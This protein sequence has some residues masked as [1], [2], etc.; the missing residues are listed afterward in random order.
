MITPTLGLLFHH[1]KKLRSF[2]NKR[3]INVNFQA[4]TVSRLL[5]QCPSLGSSSLVTPVAGFSL[6]R[7]AHP[8]IC[9][10]T[11]KCRN[12]WITKHKYIGRQVASNVCRLSSFMTHLCK[13]KVQNVVGEKS[14]MTLPLSSLPKYRIVSNNFGGLNKQFYGNK[15]LLKYAELK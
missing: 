1:L 3:N 4:S 12:T 5:Q 7:A 15:S 13:H 8:I 14:F 9:W 10:V 6:N 11:R 2:K